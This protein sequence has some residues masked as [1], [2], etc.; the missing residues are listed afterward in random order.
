M[1]I[2]RARR[3]PEVGGQLAVST[4]EEVVALLF[5]LADEKD[6]RCVATD[7]QVGMAPPKARKASPSTVW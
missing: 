5:V 2:D 1:L 7:L 3:V 4:G 6:V